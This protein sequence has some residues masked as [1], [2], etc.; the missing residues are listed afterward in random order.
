MSRILPINY[1]RVTESISGTYQSLGKKAVV[2]QMMAM[3]VAIYVAAGGGMIGRL[4]AEQPAD[5]YVDD[6]ASRRPYTLKAL[7][8]MRIALIAYAAVLGL[9]PHRMPPMPDFHSAGVF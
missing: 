3:Q 6:R 9:D 5:A 4:F 8:N 2:S 7:G 1:E